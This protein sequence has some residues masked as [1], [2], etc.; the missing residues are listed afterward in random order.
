LIRSFHVGNQHR[1]V[2]SLFTELVGFY[3]FNRCYWNLPFTENTPRED[4]SGVFSK[5]VKASDRFAP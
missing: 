2:A 4:G 1:P 5:V 3:G